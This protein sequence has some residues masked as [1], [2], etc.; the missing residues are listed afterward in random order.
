MYYNA[1]SNW[2]RET[3]RSQRK[4]EKYQKQKERSRNLKS[5]PPDPSNYTQ[6][7]VAEESECANDTIL[8]RSDEFIT[9]GIWW[10]WIIAA[11][12]ACLS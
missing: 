1:G 9:I 4:T 2:S 11:V 6:Q 3:W 7:N 8:N 5:V 12:W 10:I